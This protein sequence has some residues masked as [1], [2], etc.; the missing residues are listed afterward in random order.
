MAESYKI[1]VAEPDEFSVAAADVLRDLG[2]VVFV[3][4]PGDDVLRDADI[5]W[6]RL[7]NRIDAEFFSRAPN[8]KIIV[9]ATTGLNHVDLREAERRGIQVLSLRGETEFLRDVR[10]TAEHTVGLMLA[11]LRNVPG[12]VAHARAGG[13]NRDL[14]KGH[15]LYDKTAGI[16][17]YGRLGKLVARYLLAFGVEVRATDP[18]VPA[19][20]VEP[21]V[22]LMPFAELLSIADL[23]TVHANLTDANER[24]FGACEFGQMKEGAWFINT[25]RGELVDEDALLAALESGRLG[26]AAIDVLADEQAAGRPRRLVEY[27]RRNANL[28][29]TPHIGGCTHESMEKTELFLAN[30]LRAALPSLV[31]R[32]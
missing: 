22:S 10:A 27:A 17:G 13:W 6:V 25:A 9:T 5:V 28:L 23:I 29:I 8:V 14:F 24:L 32:V 31:E 2:A 26:G 1:V 12:A 21:G 18:N 3:N 11:L 4:E 15:E 20:A 19:L 16:V 30:K 7:R